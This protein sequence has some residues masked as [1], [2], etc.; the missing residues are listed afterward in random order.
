MDLYK[1]GGIEEYWIVNP[2]SEEINIYWFKEREV[3]KTMTFKRR[4]TAKSFVFQGLGIDVDGVF[5]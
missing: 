5:D 4:D 1:Q 3:E 2:F